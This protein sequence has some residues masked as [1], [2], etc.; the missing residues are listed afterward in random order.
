MTRRIEHI[1]SNYNITNNI[2]FIFSGDTNVIN[3]G[4]ML[5]RNT[6]WM[7]YALKEVWDIGANFTKYPQIGMGYDNA[8]FSMF[9]AGCNGSSSESDL[10][11]CYLKSDA[12]YYSINDKLA[13][14]S[15]NIE[16]Y[17]TL[18]SPTVF[19]HVR[20]VPHDAFNC[21]QSDR[22][23]FILHFAGAHREAKLR[24]VEGA[25]ARLHGAQV[26]PGAIANS[27]SS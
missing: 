18:L 25:I 11:Q 26:V 27:S 13:I 2:S 19:P 10:R 16:F 7:K 17:R 20:P 5:L 12:G 24:L 23:E 9:L 21:Y 15:A 4:V 6:D 22:A 3:T 8:A 14:S 1:L